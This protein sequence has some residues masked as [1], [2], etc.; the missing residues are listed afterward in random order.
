LS[1]PPGDTLDI[2]LVLHGGTPEYL[3][4]VQATVNQATNPTGGLQFLQN[5]YA[6]LALEYTEFADINDTLGVTKGI[7][8]MEEVLASIDFLASNPFVPNDFN[9]EKIYAFGISRG[10]ANALLAGIERNLSAVI[11]TSAPLDWIAIRDSIESGFLKPSDK[12]LD[13]FNHTTA[14]WNLDT[15][16]WTTYSAG[17]RVKASQ[18]PFLVISGYQDSLAFIDMAIRMQEEYLMCDTCVGGSAFILHPFG[19]TDWGEQ[20]ILNPIQ[21]FMSNF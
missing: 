13:N 12:E 3:K 15:T 19:H 18:S 16:H 14:E 17:L 10:G 7:T 5:G 2:V 11:S 9:I 8:E 6:I 21:N 20:P 1:K 4:S